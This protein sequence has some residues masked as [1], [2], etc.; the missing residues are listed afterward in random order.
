MESNVYNFP[1]LL[2]SEL[3]HRWE[4]VFNIQIG[5]DYY[6]KC[7]AGYYYLK[8]QINR[9]IVVI[10]HRKERDTM[11][12]YIAYHMSNKSLKKVKPRN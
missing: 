11:K 3:V 10:E 5:K 2:L 8:Q 7:R 12:V 4:L 9:P 1:G 6:R